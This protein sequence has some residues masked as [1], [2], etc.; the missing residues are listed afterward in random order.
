MAN[1]PKTVLLA[2]NNAH[3][4]AEISD[5]L[6][7]TGWRFVTLAQAGIVSDP[8]ETGTT[9]AENAR[10]KALAAHAASGMASLADDSGLAVDA[11]GGAP[12]IFSA[13]YAGDHGHDKDNN[14]LVLRN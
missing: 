9:F 10:I 3:K 4:A 5:A 11:L 2:T 6:A 7:F 13:R 8:E 14:A 12:G 1:A